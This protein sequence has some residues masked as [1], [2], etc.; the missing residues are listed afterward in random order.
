MVCL[1]DCYSS[2]AI[3][4]TEK[5]SAWDEAVNLG[6][7]IL[8]NCKELQKSDTIDRAWDFVTGW[9]TS[10]KNRFLPDNTPCYRKI[11]QN[12][13]YIIPNILRQALLENVF[14]Y[15]KVTRG[16]KERGFIE[17][18][19]DYKGHAKMQ[20]PRRINGVLQK[21]FCMKKILSEVSSDENRNTAKPLD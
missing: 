9:I 12:R 5:N 6:T 8:Q 19:K 11:E 15:S 1:G 17:I 14:D 3:F 13:M 4:N 10:N 7:K 21:C 18:Q 20:V 2:I 16:F